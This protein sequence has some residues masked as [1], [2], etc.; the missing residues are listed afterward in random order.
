[1]F[2]KNRIITDSFSFFISTWMACCIMVVNCVS[3][4]KLVQVPEPSNSV[5]TLETFR[6]EA[7]ATSA[8]TAI[9]SNM[10]RPYGNGTIASY[11]SGATTLLCGLSADELNLFSAATDEDNFQT[12]S[13]L[14][15]N[16]DINNIFWSA[17][18]GDIYKAN[19]V[20][21]GVQSSST[22]SSA[23]KNQLT[24]EA[25]FIRAFCH[26]Y[27]V[28]LFGDIPL[29]TTTSFTSTSLIAR[30]SADKVYKQIFVDLQD[31]QSLLQNDYA[32]SGG[33]RIRAN[34]WA[35]TALL[36]RVYLYTGKW[37]DAEIQAT[38]IIENGSY[39]LVNDLNGV[40]LMNNTEA[41]LQLKAFDDDPW[42]TNEGYAIIPYDSTSSPTYYLTKNLLSAFELGD[43][44]RISWLDST[45]YSGTY[46]YYPF[47]YKVRQ[48]TP[49]NITEYYTILRLSE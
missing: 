30:T 40:F 24:G 46:Y 48:G 20:I 39:N 8:L 16:S 11:G 49:G 15:T 21:E 7:N 10:S 43:Q 14:S 44:R 22:L 5:T 13:L 42:A 38:S 26:F 28:N 35:A 32:V 31:A 18:Y 37:K 36:A 41:I 19:A 34:K 23:V 4:N 47:K 17:I 6:T 25:K 1:M 33:E 27:L 9:Y 2:F 45:D 29:V 12:N 3:C